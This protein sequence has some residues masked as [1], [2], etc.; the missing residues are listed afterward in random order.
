MNSRLKQAL[1]SCKL[2]VINVLA[3][4]YLMT[5]YQLPKL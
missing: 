5:L 4:A 1:P 2:S 3:V